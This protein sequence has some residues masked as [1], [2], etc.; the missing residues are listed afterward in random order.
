M[1]NGHLS[2]FFL[3]LEL[4]VHLFMHHNTMQTHICT[5]KTIGRIVDLGHSLLP[6]NVTCVR[7]PD[8]FECLYLP[9][10]SVC[11]SVCVCACVC[12]CVY[13]CV[14]MCVCMWV[15]VCLYVSIQSHVCMYLYVYVCVCW[16]ILPK[17]FTFLIF[18]YNHNY[19]FFQYI[20]I[21]NDTFTL[22][23]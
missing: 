4:Y 11:V 8:V 22:L 9:V 17:Y 12:V 19:L 13:V 5:Y 14:C 18:L 10:C 15:H 3:A 6:D 1:N 7:V 23:K 21:P 20:I 16:Y 2:H